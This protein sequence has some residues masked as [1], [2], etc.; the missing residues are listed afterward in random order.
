MFF[1]SLNTVEYPLVVLGL[2][3]WAI[4]NTTI[5]PC[6]GVSFHAGFVFETTFLTDEVSVSNGEFFLGWLGIMSCV[7]KFVLALFESKGDEH[8][9]VGLMLT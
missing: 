6:V 7:P 8:G 3:Q 1:Q 5:D 9:T 2:P 4:R